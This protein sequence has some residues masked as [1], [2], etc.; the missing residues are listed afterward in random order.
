MPSDGCDD[1]IQSLVR[2]LDRAGV[3]HRELR[4]G[5]VSCVMFESPRGNVSVIAAPGSIGSDSGLLESYC[6]GWD[7]SPRGGMSAAEIYMEY[8][9]GKWD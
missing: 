9:H 2:K 4:K 1:E 3:R 8:M 7:M 6:E 5:P